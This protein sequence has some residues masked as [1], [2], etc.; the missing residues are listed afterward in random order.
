MG[1]VEFEKLFGAQVIMG[2]GKTSALKT[3][4]WTLAHKFDDGE[5]A[6]RSDSQLGGRRHPDL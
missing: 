3:E 5:T 4:A 2:S 6:Q 1:H